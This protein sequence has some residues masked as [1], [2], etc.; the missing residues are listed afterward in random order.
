MEDGI[1]IDGMISALNALKEK[2]GGEQRIVVVSVGFGENDYMLP[3]Y[4][5]A[6]DFVDQDGEGFKCAFIASCGGSEFTRK[7]VPH[8]RWKPYEDSVDT[9]SSDGGS[10]GK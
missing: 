3:S 2:V 8:Y 1:T 9:E 5:V 4:P 10:D 6:G 7:G